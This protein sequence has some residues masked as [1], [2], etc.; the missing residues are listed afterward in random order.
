MSKNKF[1]TIFTILSIAITCGIAQAGNTATQTIR[2]KVNPINK[3]AVSGDPGMLVI[4]EGSSV[5]DDSTTYTVTTNK[6]NQKITAA[7]DAD[8]P[9]GLELKLFLE[10]PEGA[11]A[12]EVVLST[13]PRDVVT[14]IDPVAASD[15][16]ISYTLSG[17]T[18]PMEGS[19]KVTFTF[20]DG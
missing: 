13:S 12:E 1:I 6:T 14:K 4:T 8:M 20:V 18:Q 10:P 15:M 9:E 7:I 2:I 5:T 17:G 11:S 3:I 16:K 19:F